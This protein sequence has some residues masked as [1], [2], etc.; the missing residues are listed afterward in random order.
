M[1]ARAPAVGTT[2]DAAFHFELDEYNGTRRAQLRVREFEAAAAHPTGCAAAA[3]P[4]GCVG[5]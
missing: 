3:H 2:I 5:G 1:A 4:T